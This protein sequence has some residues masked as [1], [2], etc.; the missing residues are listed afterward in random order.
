MSISQSCGKRSAMRSI[1]AR[2]LE[3]TP[4]QLYCRRSDPERT[5]TRNGRRSGGS[6]PFSSLGFIVCPLLPRH[7][8]SSRG[9]ALPSRPDGS[10]EPSHGIYF[11][12]GVILRRDCRR[13]ADRGPGRQ[14]RCSSSVVCSSWAAPSTKRRQGGSACKK[15]FP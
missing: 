10:G 15:V 3:S 4:G 5:S 6:L 8:S 13:H 1:S 12:A 9:T 14:K 7:E 11:L 2:D